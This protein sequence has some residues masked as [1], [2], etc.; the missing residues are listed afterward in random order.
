[1]NANLLLIVHTF[2]TIY[3]VGLIWMVQ[4]VHYELMDRV[5]AETFRQYEADHNRY[6]SPIVGPP[7]MIE[8]VTG[9]MLVAGIGPSWVSRPEAI[10]GLVAIALIWLSTMFLQVPAHGRLLAGFDSAAYERLVNTNWIR[11]VL[12]SLRGV[13]V[14]YWLWRGLQGTTVISLES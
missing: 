1:M 5:G 7:M 6:I 4:C 2:C 10:V 3:L 11:T 13:L 12:W 9:L 8:M 14:A